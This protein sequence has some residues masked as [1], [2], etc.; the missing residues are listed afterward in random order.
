MIFEWARKND[1]VLF[2]HDMDFGALLAG[3][4]EG[5]PR[6]IQV[7]AQDVMPDHLGPLVIR[8]L[9]Q[10]G[11]LLAKGALITVEE[12]RARVRVLPIHERP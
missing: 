6:V 3:T 9:R 2:N 10:Y 1:Y 5:A 4:Q 8:V 7:R 12:A 11:T